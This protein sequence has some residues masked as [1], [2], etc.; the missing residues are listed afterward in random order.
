MKVAILD[1]YVDEPSCL[2]V[3]PYISPYPRYIYG[4]LKKLG[5][6]PLYTTI[7]EIRRN[8]K[9]KKSLYD[10]DLVI[11]IAGAIVPGKYVG[12]RPLGFDEL[13]S[14]FPAEKPARKI[15]VG[16]ITLEISEKEKRVLENYEI[17][18][19]P[20]ETTLF[21]LLA[22]ETESERNINE[23]SI[24]GAEVIRQHPDFPNVICE[25]E[26]YKGCFW[27]KCSFC[28]ERIHGFPSQRDPK[29]V[30][31]EIR[32][33]YLN[34]CRYFRL[35]NQTDFF[36]YMGDFSKEVPKPNP[37]AMKNFHRAIWRLC[38]R[39][40]VLHMDNANPKTIATWPEES[41]E[42]VKTVVT[43]Q[44]PGNVAAMGLESADERVIER[45]NLAANPEEVVEAIKLLNVYG[46]QIGYNGM[47]C[48]LP[49]LNFVIG[50]R[51]ERKET[52]E[53][54]FSF[55]EGILEQDLWVR[56]INIRQVKI[57]PGTPM[58]QFGD[59]LLR[60]HKRYFRIFRERVREKID[61][62]FLKRMLPLGRKITDVRCEYAEG[63]HTY[64]R[65]LATYPLLI[66]IKGRYPRDTFLDVRIVDY[67]RR[68]ITA[69]EHSG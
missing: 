30:I 64:G 36:A 37:A 47:P 32:A 63:N 20:F 62:E 65:Q 41:R 46:R 28:I 39:I 45:N 25:I 44:T 67:G 52:F 66:G 14:L 12:G 1:G 49:G 18:D 16:P 53:K 6:Q 15:L 3:P 24:A 23:F 10:F 4:M 19:F 68:S 57:L 27:R 40:R 29:A 31:E 56:R 22:N 5:S 8:Y 2:G 13:R 33:L 54:N 50:L 17:L 61:K 42:I 35:G 69:V 9:L 7:D 58:Y 38:P 51:G 11:V 55:L 43:Y 48:F 59:R 26:T 21:G 34:G 60:R